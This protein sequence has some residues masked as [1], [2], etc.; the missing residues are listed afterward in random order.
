MKQTK[1]KENKKKKTPPC[2]GFW[3][4]SLDDGG[5]DVPAGENRERFS[6][7]RFEESLSPGKSGKWKAL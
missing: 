5:T 2:R 4:V 1:L 3:L 7:V 6:S